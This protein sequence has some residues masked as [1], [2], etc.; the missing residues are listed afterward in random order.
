MPSESFHLAA[1]ALGLR[2]VVANPVP[3]HHGFLGT[4]RPLG[5]RLTLAVLFSRHQRCKLRSEARPPRLDHAVG[6]PRRL[7]QK[8]T[9]TRQ[10]RRFGHLALQPAEGAVLLT[11]HQPEQHGHEVLHLRLAETAAE[12][13]GELTQTLIQAYNRHRHSAPP[14]AEVSS[15]P[16]LLPQGA[17]CRNS[18]ALNC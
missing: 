6:G 7:A 10:R 5:A 13:E 1:L 11:Q 4:T 15:P 17:L 3:S 18:V 2:R 12:G 16:L 9:E 14:G 8:P